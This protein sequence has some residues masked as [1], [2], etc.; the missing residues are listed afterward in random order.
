MRRLL[1][2]ASLLAF[3]VG[4]QFVACS[5]EGETDPAGPVSASA[6]DATSAAPGA[7]WLIMTSWL[8]IARH[9]PGKS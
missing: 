7:S 3:V 2:F 1:P 4:S 8:P 9:C 5:D 6:A